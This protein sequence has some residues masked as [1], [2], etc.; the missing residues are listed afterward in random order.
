M[1]FCICKAAIR[2]LIISINIYSVY[3]LF[4]LML[5]LRKT[6]FISPVSKV[7]STVFP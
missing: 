7:F 4:S 6:I 1:Y 5:F 2:W 3:A